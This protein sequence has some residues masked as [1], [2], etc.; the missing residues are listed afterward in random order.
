MI[1]QTTAPPPFI[2]IVGYGGAGD[3]VTDD[4]NAWAAAIAQTQAA[5]FWKGGI[6]VTP[7]GFN[8]LV[9][10][11]IVLDGLKNITILAQGGQEGG[12]RIFTNR[13]DGGP[14]ISAKS[15]LSI[16]VIGAELYH[17]GP[18]GTAA[19]VIDAS[20]TTGSP[21][22]FL[23]VERCEVVTNAAAGSQIDVL[24]IPNNITVKLDHSQFSGG[25]YNIQGRGVVA[26]FV[27][28]LDITASFFGASDL[29]AIHNLGAGTEIH[30]GTVFEPRR[31]SIPGA[32]LQDP[33]MAVGG[34]AINGIWVGD[35]AAA[36]TLITAN[37]KGISILGSLIAAGNGGTAIQFNAASDGI[38]IAANEFQGWTLGV[39]KNAQTVTNIQLGPNN[40]TAVTTPTN[41]TAA[42][43]LYIE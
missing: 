27:N 12:S 36:G 5:S 32:L 4:T 40:Y 41:F 14:V 15:S 33:T 22:N 21:T 17:N 37:G 29:C 9:Q 6:I 3:G 38:L 43:T 28:S 11:G 1:T 13:T 8:S 23:R 25:R 20:G 39:D 42:G 10:G 2:D 19:A 30:G 7:P 24:R 18:A 35:S 16:S 34:L 26:D 31:G